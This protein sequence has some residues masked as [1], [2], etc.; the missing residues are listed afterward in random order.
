MLNKI[1]TAFIKSNHQWMTKYIRNLGVGSWKITGTCEKLLDVKCDKLED[2]VSHHFDVHSTPNHVCRKTLHTALKMLNAESALII[3]TGSSA[4]GSNSSL[5]FD[6]YVRRFGGNFESVDLR[7]EPS[8]QLQKKCSSR[9]ILH[10][11]DSVHF[12]QKWSGNHPAQKIDLLYLDSWDV[13]WVDPTPSALHGLAEFLAAST[14]LKNGSLLLVDD[15]PASPEFF[16]SAQ[17]ELGAFIKY[18]SIHGFYPGK[19]SLIKKLLQSLG[20]GKE[21]MHNYQLLWQF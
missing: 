3:E 13:N 11:D 20:R 17:S 2:V 14:H 1:Q 18:Q 8:V 4:W 12:L 9:T 6:A 10:C 19:G 21:I 15:T 7:I 5:L 16:I